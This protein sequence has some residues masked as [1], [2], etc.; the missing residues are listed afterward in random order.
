MENW[1]EDEV[2]GAF[3]KKKS[4]WACLS[5]LNIQSIEWCIVAFLCVGLSLLPW[6]HSPSLLM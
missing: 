1:P 6:L 4:I 3:E 5:S 2:L